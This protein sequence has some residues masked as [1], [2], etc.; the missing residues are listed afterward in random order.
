MRG[1][2]GRGGEEEERG[3]ERRER[4]RGEEERGRGRGG[5]RGGRGGERMRKRMGEEG[6]GGREG[7]KMIPDSPLLT[8]LMF[9]NYSHCQAHFGCYGN[10][11]RF[12][13]APPPTRGRRLSCPKQ[14]K[15]HD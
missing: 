15:N 8:R 12:H 13:L 1:E 3:G 10:T 6:R 4:R 11:G 2:R 14:Q 7:V 9:V 5:V